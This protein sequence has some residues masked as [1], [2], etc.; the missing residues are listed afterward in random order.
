M[1]I[2]FRHPQMFLYLTLFSNGSSSI[3]ML[4]QVYVWNSVMEKY[5]FRLLCEESIKS[6][7]SDGLYSCF[8]PLRRPLMSWQKTMR[9]PNLTN[10][11]KALFFI[12]QW[13]TS[14]S[15]NKIFL[16]YNLEAR[17]P[18]LS[19]DVEWGRVKFLFPAD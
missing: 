16:S 13:Q 2:T 1:P 3:F 9:P 8:S 10:I 5:G 12:R 14:T 18:A 6:R 19:F 11:F 17:S 4:S 7:Q 15:L